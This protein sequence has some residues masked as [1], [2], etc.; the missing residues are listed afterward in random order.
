MFSQDSAQLLGLLA[1]RHFHSSGFFLFYGPPFP[2][3][4][5]LDASVG[6]HDPFKGK[7]LYQSI[8]III[9]IHGHT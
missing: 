6:L 3:F 7:A 1:S 8:A 5:I 2:Q 4:I 9:N